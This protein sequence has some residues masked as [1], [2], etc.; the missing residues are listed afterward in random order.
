MWFSFRSLP[1]IHPSFTST[2]FGQYLLNRQIHFILE[3]IL[4]YFRTVR[5]SERGKH[6]LAILQS[7]SRPISQKYF[8]HLFVHSSRSE[9]NL[10]WKSQ[11]KIWEVNV[12]DVRVRQYNT[13]WYN[14][15][16]KKKRVK[17]A[18]T[19]NFSCKFLN[20]EGLLH[21]DAL[22]NQPYSALCAFCF[23]RD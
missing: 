2:R 8:K 14:F 22:P 6:I 19:L 13:R 5:I 16:F 15:I 4:K 11:N 23:Y 21:L 12:H 7:I 3:R 18:G 10:H 1:G 20:V 17:G 9:H